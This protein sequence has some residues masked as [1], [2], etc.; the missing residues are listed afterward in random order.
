MSRFTISIW[1]NSLIMFAHKIF[2]RKHIFHIEWFSQIAFSKVYRKL[3]ANRYVMLICKYTNIRCFGLRILVTR[4]TYNWGLDKYRFKISTVKFKKCSKMS[5][6]VTLTIDFHNSCQ[7]QKPKNYCIVKYDVW[8]DNCYVG[9]KKFQILMA[10]FSHNFK[11]K[12]YQKL[13]LTN[14]K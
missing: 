13:K 14:Q 5:K 8:D 11:L 4:E 1:L 12:S 2:S 3:Y 10:N 9:L 7:F 6:L